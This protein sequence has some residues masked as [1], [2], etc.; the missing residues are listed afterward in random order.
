M[1]Q[2]L[3][4]SN[5]FLLLDDPYYCGMKARVPN[6]VKQNG[7]IT[8]GTVVEKKGFFS[9]SDKKPKEVEKEEKKDS[10]GNSKGKETLTPRQRPSVVKMPHPASFS[11]LYQL[12]QMQNGMLGTVSK[13]T[14]FQRNNSQPEPHYPM[15]AAKSYESGIGEKS[16]WPFIIFLV[17][18]WYIFRRRTWNAIPN[19][20]S[21]VHAGKGLRTSYTKNESLRGRVGVNVFVNKSMRE[22]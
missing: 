14:T 21:N 17:K 22:N 3:G 8:N 19:L 18:I 2:S 6:F 9:K 12:H 20:R 16:R 13:R 10:T 4:W 11:T 7:K 5:K 1:T 15:W